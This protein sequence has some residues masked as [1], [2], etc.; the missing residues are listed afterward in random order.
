[1]QVEQVH[2]PVV[3]QRPILMVQPVWRTI[4]ISQLQNTGW[5]MSLLCRLSCFPG[6]VVQETVEISQL[7]LL[8]NCWLPVVLAALRGGVGLMG[9]F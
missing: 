8:R 5:L 6:A 7:L 3:T 1:M 9:I 2:F 4:E